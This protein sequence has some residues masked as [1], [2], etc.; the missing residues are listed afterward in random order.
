[1]RTELDIYV[2]ITIA[3]SIPLLVEY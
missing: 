2:C 1:V 3:G